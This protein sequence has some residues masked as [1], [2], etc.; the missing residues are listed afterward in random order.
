LNTPK[1]RGNS[2]VLTSNADTAENKLKFSPC[3]SFPS[4]KST[5]MK[6]TEAQEINQLP[7]LHIDSISSTYSNMAGLDTFN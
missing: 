4:C 3:I 7:D 1:E 6:Q 5:G 2:V